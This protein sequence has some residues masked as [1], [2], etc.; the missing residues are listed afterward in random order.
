MAADPKVPTFDAL[1]WPALKAMK[2]LGGSATHEELL[3]KVIEL[4]HIP[5]AVQ[6]VMHTD[7]QTKLSYNLAWA[8]TYLGKFGAMENPSHGVWAITERGKALTEAEVKQI[9][10]E[11]RKRYK[12]K[13]AKTQ[14]DLEED[15]LEAVEGYEIGVF[16]VGKNWKDELL[17]VVMG[18]KPDAFERLAQRILRESGFAKVE[19]TGRS[20][21]G[22]ID[23]AGVLRLALLS[24][25][26][27]FQ[28]KKYK[29]SISSGAIRDFRGAMAGRTDKG[30]FITTGTFSAEAKKEATRD[31][32]PPIDLID[33]DQ[34]CELLKSLTRIS[35]TGTSKKPPSLA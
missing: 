5:E 24:F 6:N 10:G 21:D 23:G 19:V 33:G 18:M 34:L 7:R 28:C 13:K 26:V 4:D 35:H 32:V 2:A 27:Y 30:L 31:G 11:V 1:M 12:R 17:T 29:G 9:P 15:V 25:Q 14:D 16:K 3:E 22:G 8:K 20:G